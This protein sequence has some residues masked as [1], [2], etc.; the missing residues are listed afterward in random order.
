MSRTE[1]DV[2]KIANKTLSRDEDDETVSLDPTALRARPSL[3]TAAR[4]SHAPARTVQ[5]TFG[6]TGV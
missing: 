6:P 4:R 5:V 3:S 1:K 2:R